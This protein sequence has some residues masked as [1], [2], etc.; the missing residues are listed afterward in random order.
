METRL[1]SSP[2]KYDWHDGAVDYVVRQMT[3]WLAHYGEDAKHPH[4]TVDGQRQC[5]Y[6]SGAAAFLAEH[7]HVCSKCFALEKLG[8]IEDVF[9]DTLWA[10]RTTVT[11]VN[12]DSAEPANKD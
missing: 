8:R 12:E 3:D 6:P 5:P 2:E 7:G 10:Y 4:G 11:V 1:L 9:G